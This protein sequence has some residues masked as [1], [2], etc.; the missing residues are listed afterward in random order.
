MRMIAGVLL[1]LL[2]PVTAM[3]QTYVDG[4]Y[5]KD[6]TYVQPHYRSSP[7]NSTLDNWSTK[8]NTNPYTGQQGTRSP[9]GSNNSGG[10]SGYGS[11]QQRLNCGNGGASAWCR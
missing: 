3:A 11:T 10:Y 5:R 6:G 4:Y 1:A 7:N 8:G 9:Y 2:L